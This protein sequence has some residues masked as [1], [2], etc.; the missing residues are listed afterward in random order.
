LGY[1]QRHTSLH[2]LP[3]FA[4]PPSSPS[5]AADATAFLKRC[6]AAL[7]PGG[8]I[9]IKENV[10]ASGFEVDTA[11]ASVTRSHAYNSQLYTQGTGLR[12]AH[13]ALQ[14]DFP[15]QLFKVRMY[16]LKA[17]AGWEEAA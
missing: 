9:L 1:F 2:T 7:K 3:P 17:D 12:L 8:A 4:L 5:R 11:D 14:R 10:C 15:R 16:A 13:T 6:A